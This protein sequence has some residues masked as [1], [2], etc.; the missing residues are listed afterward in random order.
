MRSLQDW[1]MAQPAGGMDCLGLCLEWERDSEL[2]NVLRTEKKLLMMQAGEEICL[3]SRQ[4]CVANA[5]VL[6]PVLKRLARSP[7]YKLPH[8]DDMKV[9]VQTV[10]E[11]CGVEAGEK[12]IYQNSVEIK[13]LAGLIKR[14]AARKEVTKEWGYAEFIHTKYFF[15]CSICSN[16]CRISTYVG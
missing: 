13:R 11:K 16:T 12:T 1:A 7:K 9:E 6:R 2:R 5:R 10:Y 4:N 8:L 14:R 3:P 15:L